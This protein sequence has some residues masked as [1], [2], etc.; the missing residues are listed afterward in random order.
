MLAEQ[1]SCYKRDAQTSAICHI[2]ASV[3]RRLQLDQEP[4]VDYLPQGFSDRKPNR[5]E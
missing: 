1:R 3:A 2:A 5:Q 4:G